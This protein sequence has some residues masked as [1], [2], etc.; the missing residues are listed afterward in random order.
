MCFVDYRIRKPCG[1]RKWYNGPL[2]NYS[3]SLIFLFPFL[4]VTYEQDFYNLLFFTIYYS[5]LKTD[6]L[7]IVLGAFKLIPSSCHFLWFL[8]SVKLPVSYRSPELQGG[9]CHSV[10][11]TQNVF[12]SPPTPTN[13]F[14]GLSCLYYWN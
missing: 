8:P 12:S 7:E 11:Q 5:S 13:L 14:T 9:V 2:L 3:K 1:S 4:H 10:P 6:Q